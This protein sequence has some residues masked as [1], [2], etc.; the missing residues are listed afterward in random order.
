MNGYCVVSFCNWDL[1]TNE[2]TMHAKSVIEEESFDNEQVKS[3]S[4][5][6]S[7]SPAWSSNEAAFEF[8]VNTHASKI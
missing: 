4:D 7:I 3:Q 1:E 5:S 6:E 8:H 2:R